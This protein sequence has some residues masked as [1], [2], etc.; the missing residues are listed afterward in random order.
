MIAVGDAR[1]LPSSLKRMFASA[2]DEEEIAVVTG[3]PEVGE[4][5]TAFDHLVFTGATS[6]ARHVMRAAAANLVPDARARRQESCGDRPL[7]RLRGGRAHHERQ[8]F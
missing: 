5:S 2:F 3:G 7:G 1:D 4:P 6:I 8:D